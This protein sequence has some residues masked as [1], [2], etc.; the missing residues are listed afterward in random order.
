M[1]KF[2]RKPEVIEAVQLTDGTFDEC[3]EFIDD[4][5]ICEENRDECCITIATLNGDIDAHSGDWIIKGALNEF[6]PCK[7]NIFTENYEPIMPEM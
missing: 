2:R 5:S 7:P 1:L 6:Y 3:L 4:R